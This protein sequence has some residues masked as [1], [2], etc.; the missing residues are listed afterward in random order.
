MAETSLPVEYLFTL[1]GEFD[2][3][4]QV[5]DG[6][7]GTRRIVSVPRGTV[8]GP[9]VRGT[10]VPP[11]GD[12]VWTHPGGQSWTLDVRLT[13]LTDDGAVILMTYRGIG[14]RDEAT[15]HIRSAPLFETG[16]ERYAWLTRV[17]AVGIG[18]RDADGT[19]ITYEVYALR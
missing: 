17:Q 14:W 2:A 10:I 8:E 5:T 4:H 6:P 18:R 1:V 15:M 3:V 12:W 19:T 13:L 11:T 16:D 9:R 7:H